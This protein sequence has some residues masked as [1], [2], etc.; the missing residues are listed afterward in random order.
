M[1]SREIYGGRR[2]ER[3]INI[4]DGVTAVALTLLAVP[5]IGLGLPQAGEDFGTYLAQHAGSVLS[6]AL[7]FAIVFGQWRVHNRILSDLVGYDS[8]VFWINAAWLAS[9]AFLPWPSALVGEDWES[10]RVLE[11]G[12]GGPV[13]LFYWLSMAW[14]VLMATA[15]RV[16]LMRHPTLV[17]PEHWPSWE[18]HRV[19]WR[20]RSAILVG[21]FVVSA[22][23]WYF[24][25]VAGVTCLVVIV[26]ALIV[27]AHRGGASHAHAPSH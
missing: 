9:I 1:S 18:A 5:L 14:A 17:D 8:F 23:A 21:G 13:A 10:G 6:F 2:L 15:M 4:S 19:A 20:R 24:S 16:Y 12:S 26:A 25:V 22:V 27:V 11:S 7:T 3:L